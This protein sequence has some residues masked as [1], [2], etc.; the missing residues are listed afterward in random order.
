[1]PKSL[2]STQED[3]INPTLLAFKPR[4]VLLANRDMEHR[5]PNSSA[6]GAQTLSPDQKG[7]LLRAVARFLENNGFSKT[8][9]KFLSEAG[10]EKSELKDLPLDLGEIYCKYSE[11]RSGDTNVHSEEK[12]FKDT[13]QLLV[14]ADKL[15]KEARK[16]K[17]AS[18]SLAGAAEEH[19]SEQFLGATEKKI[20]DAV[21]LKENGVG[22]SEIEKKPKVKKKKKNKSSTDSFSAGV[23]QHGLEGKND[24]IEIGKSVADDNPMD[25]KSVKPKSKKKKKDGLVSESLGGEKGKALSIGD[26]NGTSSGKYDF[27]ISDVDAT[28][29]EN[30][31]SKKR[32]RLAS[33]GNDSQPADNKE[34]EESKRRKVESS[35]SSKGSEQPVNNNA[36]QGKAENFGELDKSAEKSSIKKNK[37]QHNGSAEPKTVNAFQRVKADE[38]EFVDEKLRDN[39][40]WAKDG[41]EIGYGAKAQEILGQVRGRDFRHEKTK[42]KRGTYRGGLIDLQSHSVKF[43]YSDED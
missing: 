39:S 41:A 2:T 14:M 1:M 38:V 35:K 16:S 11:M 6:N 22:D 25:G 36:S 13:F 23:E 19:Q 29:K 17:I 21:L 37:K 28:D 34:D 18:G 30:K 3:A 42:K 10:I 8:L 5:K 32:K 33:E 7:P 24:A 12:V 15:S 4:Q 43:N 31:G 27:K 20:K 40:Y 9:K 26:R